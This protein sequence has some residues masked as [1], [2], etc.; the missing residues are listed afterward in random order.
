MIL[1]YIIVVNTFNILF[2]Y[3]LNYK[4]QSYFP[5]DNYA[6]ISHSFEIYGILSCIIYVYIYIKMKL[7][8]MYV[9]Y[10]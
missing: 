3:S 6:Y 8:G 9:K 4:T 10:C 2:L 5:L 7:E 1:F